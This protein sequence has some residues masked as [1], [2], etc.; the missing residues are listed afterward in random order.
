MNP[1]L[2]SSADAV[3]RASGV[4]RARLELSGQDVETLL[5]L[6]RVAAH[7]SDVRSTAPLLCYLVGLARGSSGASLEQLAAAVPRRES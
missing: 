2:S 4:E 5:D 7:D 1:W 6:A 3:A